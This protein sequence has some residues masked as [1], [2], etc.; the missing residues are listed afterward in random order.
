MAASSQ[1]S[2]FG[3]GVGSTPSSVPTV[4][5]FQRSWRPSAKLVATFPPYVA[6]RTE[7]VK[8][9]LVSALRFNTIMPL[10]ESKDQVMHGLE[11]DCR[12][13]KKPLWIDLKGRQLRITKFA[14]LPYAYVELSHKIKVRTPTQI[15][16][17]DCVG[18]IVSV[19]DGNKL[20]LADR[21]TRVVGAGEPVNI[22]DSS[23][24]I[25]GN[26]TEDDVEWIEAAKR[27][28]VHNFMLSFA[29]KASDLDEIKALDPDAKIVSKIESE[30]GLKMIEVLKL[31]SRLMAARDDLLINVGYKK[32]VDALMGIRRADENAIVASRIL[33]SVE[34]GEKVSMGDVSDI[35]FMGVIGYRHFMLSDGMCFSSAAF[36][37]ATTALA[38]LGWKP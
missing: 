19:V 29:E 32:I 17:K 37:R 27:F 3:T 11:A 7:I 21:P 13:A 15:Y 1:G 5:P 8:H 4:E 35:E 14:Y 25:E 30:R 28:D 9:P 36:R 33:T 24:E 26:L 23:L 12:V 2:Y 18:E 31:K 34:D 20:I 16:F 38:G 6:H 22:L 10:A